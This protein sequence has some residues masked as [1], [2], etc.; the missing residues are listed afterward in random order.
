MVPCQLLLDL[1]VVQQR[2]ID[3][4]CGFV[5][6]VPVGTVPLCV[7]QVLTQIVLVTPPAPLICFKSS[8]LRLRVHHDG[9]ALLVV[10]RREGA[11]SGRVD[12]SPPFNVFRHGRRHLNSRL[13]LTVLELALAEVRWIPGSDGVQL[14]DGVDDLQQHL[15][16]R[17]LERQDVAEREQI[18]LMI[19]SKKTLRR[20]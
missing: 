16:E 5:L 14:V 1:R 20:P 10:Q 6:H 4:P 9:V 11:C 17:E 18:P 2:A 19:Q 3:F 13:A 7:L 12:L 8:S 15:E